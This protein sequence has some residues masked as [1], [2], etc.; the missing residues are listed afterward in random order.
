M[1]WLCLLHCIALGHYS[2]TCVYVL[3]LALPLALPRAKPYHKHSPNLSARHSRSPFISAYADR[4]PVPQVTSLDFT[5]DG[6]L[7][8][9]GSDDQGLRV[10]D[11]QD[12]GILKKTL[13]ARKLGVSLAR[14]MHDPSTV[15]CAS[16]N[17]H[18]DHAL[19]YWTLHD[20]RYLRYFK[21][22]HASRPSSSASL[23]AR[24]IFV[25]GR[26]TR[27]STMLVSHVMSTCFG[28]NRG[29]NVLVRVW[30]WSRSPHLHRASTGH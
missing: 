25:G 3:P 13:F 30:D 1:L 18:G 24:G 7:L 23:G 27:E 16:N 26:K 29:Y 2:A 19:R 5:P 20:N 28:S 17:A 11:C 9:T 6:S 14:F 22:S 10:Y 4:E 12:Q 8:L 15:I 21:G